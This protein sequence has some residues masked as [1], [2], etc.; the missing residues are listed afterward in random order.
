MSTEKLTKLTKEDWVGWLLI[1]ITL[2]LVV[3]WG[4]VI[5]GAS[6]NPALGF[7]LS[8]VHLIQGGNI[9]YPK[10]GDFIWVYLIFPFVG[11]L[12]ALVFH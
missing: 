7:G 5:S 3:A 6:Y 10:Y 1:G 4:A 2:N 8:I 12:L 11:S 9:D